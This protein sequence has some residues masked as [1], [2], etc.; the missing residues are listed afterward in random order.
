MWGQ[1]IHAIQN[2][3]PGLTDI[4]RCGGEKDRAADVGHVRGR[5]QE[6]DGAPHAFS[7]D[8]NG[9]VG[10]MGVQPEHL[11][12]CV[13]HQSRRAAPASAI[14]CLSKAPDVRC[15]ERKAL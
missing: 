10:I 13:L 6:S 8:V 7:H 9:R 5:Q 2:G 15:G 11:F 4:E 1:N 12:A 14:R 3:F